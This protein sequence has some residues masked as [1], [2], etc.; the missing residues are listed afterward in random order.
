MIFKTDEQWI[1]P[2][3]DY[4]FSGRVFQDKKI[5]IYNNKFEL[6]KTI[7]GYEFINSAGNYLTMNKRDKEGKRL[8]WH[9]Y[10]IKNDKFKTFNWL[11]YN[12]YMGNCAK[13]SDKIVTGSMGEN[14]SKGLK[15]MAFVPETNKSYTLAERSSN[16]NNMWCA[17]W[18]SLAVY[19][20]QGGKNTILMIFDATNQKKY[21][22]SDPTSG[23]IYPYIGGNS[24]F[25]WVQK[26]S[27]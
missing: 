25:V 5:S 20:E 12:T 8:T 24:T 6:I 14:R 19:P 15:I 27:L 18:N 26:S 22:A 17:T 1:S 23:A 2:T 13:N 7:E 21:L 4:Y 11:Y 9:C 10:D 3:G 16:M